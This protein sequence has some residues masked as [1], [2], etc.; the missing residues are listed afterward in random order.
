MIDV[1]KLQPQDLQDES[2]FSEIQKALVEAVEEGRARDALDF[3][4][5]VQRF[6]VMF[7][8]LE[9][10]KPELFRNYRKLILYIEL[11]LFEILTDDLQVLLL[12]KYFTSFAQLKLDIKQKVETALLLEDPLLV[13][14]KKETLIAALLRNQTL[15]GR[16]KIELSGR[17]VSPTIANW[18]AKY[19][20]RFGN[21]PQDELVLMDF[22]SR[23]EARSLSE[24]DREKLHTLL[25]IV[26]KLKFE[27]EPEEETEPETPTEKKERPSLSPLYVPL[28]KPKVS[29]KEVQKVTSPMGGI[30]P[31][32]SRAPQMQAQQAHNVQAPTGMVQF[33]SLADLN[34]L[35]VSMIDRMEVP[36]SQ[37]VP[38]IAQEIQ[39]VYT[40]SPESR[41]HI[42][43]LWQQS[44][45]YKLYL[46]MGDE[47]LQMKLPIAQI[48]ERRA[49]SGQPTLTKEMFHLVTELNDTI[50]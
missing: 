13:D 50:Q 43:D 18:V 24:E 16:E 32:V 45:L 1:A 17:L 40:R 47:S 29:L 5:A 48:A 31:Q 23:D 34:K 20:L 19:R 27:E 41:R 14:D 26:E 12:E 10:Q 6:F 39:K 42:V 11:E 21:K 46:A 7:K 36:F 2:R 28:K 3:R 33:R 44:P 35:D 25:Q 8:D 9:V 4:I 37:F 38:K 30:R 15:I 22:T 49:R